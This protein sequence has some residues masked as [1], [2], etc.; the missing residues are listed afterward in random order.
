MVER[1]YRTIFFGT[2]DF[3]IPSLK[4]LLTCPQLELCAVIT[5][6]DKPVGRNRHMEAPPVKQLAETACIPVLQPV[7]VRTP[8]F[9]NT[10]REYA[11]DI[12]VL[13][14]Y[15]K[16]IP[17]NL[18]AVPQFGWIN[19]HASLLPSLRGASPIQHAILDGLTETGI[20]IIKLDSGMD[21]GPILSQKRV[22]VR[23][24]EIFVTLHNQL[25]RLGADLLTETIIPYLE[26]KLTP[27]PQPSENVSIC[28]PIHKEDG[29]IDWAQPASH[30]E[31]MIR[32]L[33][34][35]PG[36]FS[37]WNTTMLKFISAQAYGDQHS[38][39]PGQISAIG[40][41]LRVQC[42]Q[43][44]LRITKLQPSGKRPLSDQEFIH[45]Y[46]TRLPTQLS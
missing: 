31:R 17:D 15:G 22:P 6:P 46:G 36:A 7:T 30:I 25:A 11:P 13:V 12:I 21:T 14:A 23:E 43:G 1:K 4:A 24:T 20:T 26:G 38:S 5:Q 44:V 29:K 34:P 28:A 18:L 42:G 39:S 9:E 41:E 27:T 8:D 32:A 40:N 45:G 33:T 10:L 2:P 3:A 35:W 16:I 37:T 19:V